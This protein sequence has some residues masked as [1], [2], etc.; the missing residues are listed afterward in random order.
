MSDNTIA[1]NLIVTG[2]VIFQDGPTEGNGVFG[3]TSSPGASGVVGQS[4]GAGGYGVT[5][6]S[7]L[8][9]GVLAKTSDTNGQPGLYADSPAGY[10][11]VGQGHSGIAGVYGSSDHNGVHGF[12]NSATADNSGVLGQSNVGARGVTGISQSG[13]G[14]FGG[15]ATGPG[16]WGESSGDFGVVGKTSDSR[17]AGV[18]GEGPGL[19]V[20]AESTNGTALLV[21]GLMQVQGNAVGQA[22]LPAGSMSSPPVNTPA[23]TTV[24]NIILTPLGNPGGQLWVDRAAGS[25]TIHTSAA[26]ASDVPIAYLIIN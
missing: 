15:S 6:V 11:V 24:S 17:Y 7:V 2:D 8:G 25:F 9:T 1:G 22:I 23:A 4:T 16:V 14:V 10:A 18:Y 5:G 20:W 12:T 3:N 26:P 13:I 21:R 19:G